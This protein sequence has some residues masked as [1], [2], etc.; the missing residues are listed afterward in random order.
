MQ[1]AEYSNCLNSLIPFEIVHAFLLSGA[2]FSLK[3]NFSK[4][5]FQEY[6]LMSNY[7]LRLDSDQVP[8]FAGADLGPNC[9][10]SYQQTTLVAD[11]CGHNWALKK[12]YN[13]LSS[14]EGSYETANLGILTRI[15]SPL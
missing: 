10:Q 4:K 6:H 5:F 11:D 8:S 13:F 14:D 7:R 15:H 12:Y 1:R 9:L 3:I 2:F